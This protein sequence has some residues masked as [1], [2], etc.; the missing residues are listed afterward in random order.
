MH[1]S[2]KECIQGLLQLCGTDKCCC[3]D[4]QALA[5]GKTCLGSPVNC[6]HS[7]TCG[8]GNALCCMGDPGSPAFAASVG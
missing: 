7:R 4:L 8:M 5:E 2:E 6:R 1:R 3:W